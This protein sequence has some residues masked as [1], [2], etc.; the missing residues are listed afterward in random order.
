[1]KVRFQFQVQ[2]Q[3]QPGRG[4]GP[5]ADVFLWGI[6]YME[7]STWICHGK[8]WGSSGGSLGGEGS[9]SRNAQR[10]GPPVVS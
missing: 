8:L 1:M 4:L 6:Y 3:L 2:L 7:A 10:W 5:D 9:E